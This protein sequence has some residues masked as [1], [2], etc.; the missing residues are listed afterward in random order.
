MGCL[1]RRVKVEKKKHIIKI[2]IKNHFY[3]HK[4]LKGFNFEIKKNLKT[5]TLICRFN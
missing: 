1:A 3:F 2:E 5:Q 4:S